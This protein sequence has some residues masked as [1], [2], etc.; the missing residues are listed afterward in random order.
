MFLTESSAGRVVE[1]GPDRRTIWE[2]VHPSY[3]D[4]QVPIVT[5]AARRD[6]AREKIASWPCSSVDTTRTVK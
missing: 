2:W 5:K 3:D 6:L 1:V 4:K